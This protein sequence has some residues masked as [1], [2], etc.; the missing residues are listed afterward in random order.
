MRRRG[1]AVD[2]FQVTREQR[3]LAVR[4]TEFLCDGIGMGLPFSELLANAYMQGLIDAVEVQQ[5]SKA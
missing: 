2:W 1:P 3:D 4:R 5:R